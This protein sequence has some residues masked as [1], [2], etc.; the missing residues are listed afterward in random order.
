MDIKTLEGSFCDDRVL[1]ALEMFRDA[2]SP[3]KIQ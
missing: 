1:I 3:S 2:H